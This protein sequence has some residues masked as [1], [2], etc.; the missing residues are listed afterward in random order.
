MALAAEAPPPHPLGEGSTLGEG[1]SPGGRS[2]PRCPPGRVG[3]G[4]AQV[5]EPAQLPEEPNGL[6]RELT[7]RAEDRGHGPLRAPIGAWGPHREVDVQRLTF[8]A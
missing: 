1:S 4:D 6:Q 3:E 8:E 5:G 7:G 2:G